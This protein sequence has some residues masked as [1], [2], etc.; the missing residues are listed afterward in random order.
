MCLASILP[1]SCFRGKS[2]AK[3][4]VYL[5]LDLPTSKK[6]KLEPILKEK[7]TK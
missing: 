5:Y 3:R 1:K 4:L 6:K 2:L 7:G